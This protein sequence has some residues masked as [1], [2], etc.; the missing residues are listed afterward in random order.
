MHN[1]HTAFSAGQH[2]IVRDERW[3]VLAIDAFESTH[4][5][6]LRGVDKSNRDVLQAVLTPFDTVRATSSSSRVRQRSRQAVL[7]TAAQ[8][9]AEA[10]RWDQTWTAA[11]ARIDLHAW[12][13]EPAVAAVSGAMRLLLAD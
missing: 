2:V 1:P 8:A 3:A 9:I 12:Q 5:L 7:A 13:L 11:T 6:K 4:L 10:V